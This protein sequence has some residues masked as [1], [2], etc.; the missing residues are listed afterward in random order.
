MFLADENNASN[1]RLFLAYAK[2]LIIL[3]KCKV[4]Q[5]LDTILDW[6]RTGPQSR[7]TSSVGTGR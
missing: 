7:W 6:A 5:N 2:R 3:Y 4:R 1:P